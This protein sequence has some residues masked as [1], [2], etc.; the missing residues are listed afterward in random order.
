VSRGSNVANY[1]IRI[2]KQC[3]WCSETFQVLP[4]RAARQVFCSKECRKIGRRPGR[5]LKAS[6]VCEACGEIFDLKS[7]KQYCCKKCIPE[8]TD[9]PRWQ[10]FGLTRPMYEQ[11][12]VDQGNKCKICSRSFDTLLTRNI[13]LDHCHATNKVRG[14]LCHSCN[15]FVGKLETHALLLEKAL[16]Y[17]NAV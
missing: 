14:V 2:T 3:R 15:A 11:M 10:K 12:I 17:I 16:E 7:L 8:H 1:G 6:K 13:H 9:L 4:C 5:W